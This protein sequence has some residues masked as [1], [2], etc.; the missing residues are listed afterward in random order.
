MLEIR[1]NEAAILPF[2]E[3]SRAQAIRYARMAGSSAIRSMRAEASRRIRAQWNIKASRVN[4]TL[5]IIFP[6]VGGEM[7]WKLRS[8]YGPTPLADFGARQT[9]KGV[10]VMIYKGGGRQVIPGSFLATM[11]SGHVGVFTRMGKKRL[12][13]QERYGPPISSIFRGTAPYVVNRG[14]DVFLSTFER[15]VIAK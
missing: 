10:S 1:V 5:S 13:I 2:L 14:R 12:P 9:S 4:K 11:K 7:V 15:L 8:S 3:R 6:Q